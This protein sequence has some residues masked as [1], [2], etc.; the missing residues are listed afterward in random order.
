MRCNLFVFMRRRG[1]LFMRE[2]EGARANP[3]KE[4]LRRSFRGFARPLH[5]VVNWY[6]LRQIH[7][8]FCADIKSNSVSHQ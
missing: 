5:R 6:A 4:N 8:W 1:F 2:V 7:S 3:P